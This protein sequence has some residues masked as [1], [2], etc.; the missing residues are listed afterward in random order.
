M[1]S[2]SCK[3]QRYSL[4]FWVFISYVTISGCWTLLITPRRTMTIWLRDD[5]CSHRT[6]PFLTDQPLN[7]AHASLS[8]SV[9]WDR[10]LSRFSL[11]TALSK[12]VSM[13]SLVL[14]VGY[15]SRRAKQFINCWSVGVI[16][17]TR[18]SSLCL[19]SFVV[20]RLDFRLGCYL[21]SIPIEELIPSMEL[22]K[23]EAVGGVDQ[24]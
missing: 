14:L 20:E 7:C 18:F 9:L 13:S 16:N 17:C 11:L 21:S 8:C 2:L 15:L 1:P 22:Q 24:H 5:F 4:F 12:M 19:E 6:A 10:Q 23:D 3:S